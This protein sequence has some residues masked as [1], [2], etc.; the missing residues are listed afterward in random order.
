MVGR[1]GFRGRGFGPQPSHQQRASHQTVSIL[2]LTNDRCLRD[3][4][5]VLV[6]P[7]QLNLGPCLPAA[8]SGPGGWCYY[9]ERTGTKSKICT[10]YIQAGSI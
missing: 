3:Y 6:R 4:D 1:A 10:R 2:F 5:I 9:A 7:M 8:K